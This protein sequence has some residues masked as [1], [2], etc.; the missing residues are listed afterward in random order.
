MSVQRNSIETMDYSHAFRSESKSLILGKRT[1][2]ERPSQEEPN[3][4]NFSF[5]A[6]SSEWPWAKKFVQNCGLYIAFGFSAGEYLA[7][8]SVYHYSSISTLI[9]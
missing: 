2:L 5:I 4:A 8:E 1:Q 3:A 7:K 6:P 9:D